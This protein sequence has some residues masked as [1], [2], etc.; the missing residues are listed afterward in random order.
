M[1]SNNSFIAPSDVNDL[2]TATVGSDMSLSISDEME[3]YLIH[4][5][6]VE[7]TRFRLDVMNCQMAAPAPDVF[8]VPE[9]ES[10]VD[11][12]PMI[13]PDEFRLMVDD[14]RRAQARSVYGC[15]SES[16]SGSE[17]ESESESEYDEYESDSESESERETHTRGERNPF[18]MTPAETKQFLQ[19]FMSD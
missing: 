15:E 11:H 18:V 19:P 4:L 9:Q 8:S 7:S 6:T 12:E 3:R 13:T 1:F 10:V 17:S 16:E 2:R 14:V 5:K